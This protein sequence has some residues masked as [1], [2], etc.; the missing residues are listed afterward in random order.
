MEK[1]WHPMPPSEVYQ[2]L[3]CGQK[4]LEAQEEIGQYQY[5]ILLKR[6][7]VLVHHYVVFTVI[8]Q[9]QKMLHIHHLEEHSKLI[10]VKNV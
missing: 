6:K 7:M 3:S 8:R 9:M 5:A 2:C 1:D 4:H 10:N